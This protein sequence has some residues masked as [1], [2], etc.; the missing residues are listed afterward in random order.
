LFLPIKN[1]SEK[2]WKGAKCTRQYALIVG[3]NAKFPSSL[4]AQDP[5]TAESALLREDPKDQALVAEDRLEDIRQGL[6]SLSERLNIP[7]LS[8]T[9]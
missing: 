8:S 4:M 7:F 9:Q 5:Y 6:Q 3:K 1:R 2:V